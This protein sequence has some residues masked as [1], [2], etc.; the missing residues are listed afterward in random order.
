MVHGH[1]DEQMAK[2]RKTKLRAGF[3]DDFV[4]F[5]VERSIQIAKPTDDSERVEWIDDPTCPKKA[6]RANMVVVISFATLFVSLVSLW[7]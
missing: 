1:S 5:K 4:I 7:R 3:E 2:G 6:F